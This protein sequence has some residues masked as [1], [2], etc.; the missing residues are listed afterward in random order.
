MTHEL[1][2]DGVLADL[3]QEVD[4]TLEISSNL[5][6][7]ITDITTNNTYTISLPR[8]A[9][10]LAMIGHSDKAG[11]AG[12]YP[13]TFHDCEYRRNGVPII[14]GGR[15]SVDDREEDINVTIYWGLFPLLQELI[16]KDKGLRDLSGSLSIPYNRN[17]DLTD[18]DTFITQGYGYANYSSTRR[19]DST[20]EWTWNSRVTSSATTLKCITNLNGKVFTGNDLGELAST[21]PLEDNGYQ[22]LVIEFLAGMTASFSV[23]GDEDYRAY[24]V[25]DYTRSVIELAPYSDEDAG[26]ARSFNVTAPADAATLIVNHHQSGPTSAV[27]TITGYVEE[28][29]GSQI[30]GMFGGGNLRYLLQPSVTCRWVLDLIAKDTGI[31]FDYGE[32]LD[33][34]IRTLAIPIID[35]EADEQTLTGGLRATMQE[36]T[37][38]GQITLDVTDT[39][40]CISAGVGQAT[41]L[42][43]AVATKLSFDIQATM[44]IYAPN[45]RPSQC[46]D[47][48]YNG[49][50]VRECDYWLYLNYIKMTIR[51]ASG[52][53]EDSVYLIGYDG[54]AMIRESQFANDT[55]SQRLYASGE[56]DVKEGDVITFELCNNRGNLS[57][58]RMYD[59]TVSIGLGEMDGVPFGAMFPIVK[60]LPDISVTDFVKTLNLLTGTFPLQK[61]EDGKVHMVAINSLWDNIGKAVDWS[62][63]LI[64]ADGTNKPRHIEYTMDGYA[65]HNYYKWKEDDN[66]SRGHDGDMR[67]EN[68][69]LEREQD[70]WELPFAA[71]DGSKI[72]LM[73]IGR[74][75]QFGSSS[76]TGQT[77]VSEGS[78]RVDCQ[79]RI[80]N[81]EENGDGKARLIFNIDL[82]S[83]FDTEYKNYRAVIA[84]PFIVTEH[85]Y[86][87][88]VDILRFDESVPVYLAQ[89]GA[90]FAVLE[91]KVNANGYTE[92][93]MIKIK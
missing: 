6:R 72:F 14:K 47:H 16:D 20:Q 92:A 31:T 1:Y 4:I 86:L 76:T 48:Y 29:D 5:F 10:N 60:N 50:L 69:T 87:R 56:L 43:V 46:I 88:D 27:V 93:K 12:D 39:I 42:R 58:Q 85:L 64:M 8:T 9:H 91:L 65:Q 35:N 18:Y 83:I 63:Y 59:G 37:T 34:Y 26:V 75:G 36:R 78:T 28:E 51:H 17:N 45:R 77:S 7:D 84:R 70:A 25:L 53:D 89:Y 90:Y 61:F 80:V 73:E 57:G 23:I 30:G 33:G 81:V 68:G 19:K 41:S 24:A 3:P 38:L 74:G 13:Y 54:L 82:Q 79:P 11:M 32:G 44:S 22:Y 67:I 71:T 66:V 52:Q 49:V 2:I 15:A 21:T 55:F 40:S 62:R